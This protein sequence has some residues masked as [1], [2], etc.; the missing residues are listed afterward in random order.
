MTFPFLS[1]L[2]RCHLTIHASRHWNSR[3]YILLRWSLTNPFPFLCMGNDHFTS[4]STG[5]NGTKTSPFFDCYCTV[6]VELD[7]ELA[8][9]IQNILIRFINMLC[10]RV[11]LLSQLL[12]TSLFGNILK[13]MSAYF[14]LVHYCWRTIACPQTMQSGDCWTVEIAGAWLAERAISTLAHQLL[15]FCIVH[16]CVNEIE[17]WSRDGRVKKYTN[18]ICRNNHIHCTSLRLLFS[19]NIKHL[20]MVTHWCYP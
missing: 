13:D 9:Q 12:N 17:G 5:R 8:L 15:Y 20:L 10:M 4:F 16:V 18:K 2:S 14:C 7:P 11:K 6:G 19:I 1:A 3:L